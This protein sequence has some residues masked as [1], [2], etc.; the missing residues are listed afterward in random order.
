MTRRYGSLNLAVVAALPGAAWLAH[1]SLRAREAEKLAVHT[2]QQAGHDHVSAQGSYEANGC[3]VVRVEYDCGSNSMAL[4][5]D[6]GRWTVRVISDEAKGIAFDP[7]R[8]RRWRVRG[9]HQYGRP[10]E[11][12]PA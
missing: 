8:P 12:G 4:T 3:G 10:P 9:D 11:T 5:K 7:G 6:N 2:L 1:T